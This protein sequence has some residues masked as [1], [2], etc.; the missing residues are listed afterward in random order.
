MKNYV[1]KGDV[2]AVTAGG[3]VAVGDVVLS[4]DIVGVAINGGVTGETISVAIEGVYNLTKLSTDVVTKGKALYWD[5]GNSRLT[6]T[7]S[8]HKL[9]GYAWNDAGSGVATVDCRLI[10]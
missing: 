5:A 3:T 7:P 1:Q 4:N 10:G 6:I 9:A 8:T 2:L